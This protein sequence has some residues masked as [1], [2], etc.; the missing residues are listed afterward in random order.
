VIV[1]STEPTDDEPTDAPDEPGS[2]GVVGEQ[3]NRF[4]PG[5]S[6][7]LDEAPDGQTPSDT[8]DPSDDSLPP[9]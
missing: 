7:P 6:K 4:A 8:T 5:G 9:G 3:P 2:P 1:T